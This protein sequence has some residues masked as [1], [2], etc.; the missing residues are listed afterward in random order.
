MSD[1][2]GWGGGLRKLHWITEDGALCNPRLGLL[3]LVEFGSA[4][5]SYIEDY[6]CKHCK[7]RLATR[8]AR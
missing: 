5:G 2:D 3:R 6:G 7:A 8:M 4:T 1:R